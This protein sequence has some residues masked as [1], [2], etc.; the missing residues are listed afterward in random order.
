MS[1][2]TAL[3]N[4]GRLVAMRRG[5]G[6][7][8]R[9]FSLA[10]VVAA[11]SLTASAS[12]ATASVTIGQLPTTT[13]PAAC[14]T[15]R[16]TTQ[17][18]PTSGN[19]YVVPATGGII[20][21]TVT[22]WSTFASADAGQS[23]A[24]K[25]FRQV[26]GMTYRAVGHDGPHDLTP[27]VLNTFPASITATPGDVLGLNSGTN[28]ADD[29]CNFTVPGSSDATLVREGDLADGE[30]GDFGT[31][32]PI[33]WRVNISAVITPTNQ[34][35]LGSLARNKKK[36]TAILTFSVPNPGEL[37]A[38]GNGVKAAGATSAKA[39]TAGNAQLLIKAKGKKKRK[40]NRKGKVKLNVAVSYTPTGG[41][42]NTQLLKV[43]LKK[44][45]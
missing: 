10:S 17:P 30:S 23:F 34:F 35:S 22:S 3:P 16:D 24:M 12:P 8:V 26:A 45:L 1:E 7:L 43:K 11:L 18:T 13:P 27:S 4:R 31:S 32:T 9:R 28:P 36:G 38:S 5:Q 14:S 41:D 2:L 29:A 40:L 44:K 15:Q 20:S 37:T 19:T 25:L 6:K 21:W 42:P 33:G 39:V